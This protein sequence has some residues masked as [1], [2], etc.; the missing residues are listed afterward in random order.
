MSLYKCVIISPIFLYVWRRFGRSTFLILLSLTSLLLVGTDLN[1]AT[2]GFRTGD[3][4]FLPRADLFLFFSL[5]F[6]SHSTW[7]LS[8]G[9][10]LE[11]IRVR[12]VVPILL[13]IIIFSIGTLHWRWLLRMSG[14]LSVL[15]GYF[16]L[17]LVRVSG[18][19]LILSL[20]PYLRALAK[21]GLYTRDR[22]AFNLFCT[23]QISFNVMSVAVGN[24]HPEWLVIFYFFV[25][26]IFATF[27]A[28]AV[29]QARRY[30]YAGTNSSFPDCPRDRF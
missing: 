10:G 7:N 29:C 16:T 22:L 26:P 23:H 9:E 1:H 4:S 19:L 25:A 2:P 21:R 28:A 24:H 12:G 17:F 20:L 8:I 14:D 13:L 5:G 27:V 3:G 15:V 6:L 11:R 30:A 18:S